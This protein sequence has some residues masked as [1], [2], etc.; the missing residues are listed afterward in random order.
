MA[1]AIA[2]AVRSEAATLPAR[3]PVELASLPLRE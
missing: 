2:Q 1:M 3:S